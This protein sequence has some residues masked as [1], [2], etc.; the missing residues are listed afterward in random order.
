MK[1][2]AV[3]IE[4]V[5][6]KEL[7]PA[8]FAKAAMNLDGLWLKDMIQNNAWSVLVT[9]CTDE[10]AVKHWQR[11][12]GVGGAIEFPADNRRHTLLSARIGVFERLARVHRSDLIIVDLEPLV[13]KEFRHH[14][15][16]VLQPHFGTRRT[17]VDDEGY[18]PLR[19]TPRF[20]D[21]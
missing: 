7:A 12:N 10:Q 21:T 17:E 9:G 4:G 16:T 5:L 13:A 14:G 20:W 19:S 1:T 18:V 6:T 11:I 3:A 2:I 15:I 8:D